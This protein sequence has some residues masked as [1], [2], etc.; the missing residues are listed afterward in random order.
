MNIY[1]L[2]QNVCRDFHTFRSAVVI[3]E[4]EIKAKLVHPNE[5]EW[6]PEE[7]VWKEG[8]EILDDPLDNP[9]WPAPAFVKATLLGK[10]EANI[11]KTVIC[12]DFNAG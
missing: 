5:F 10:A 3:A 12:V 8:S 6:Y 7:H 9:S 2:E 1:L 4:D 11:K